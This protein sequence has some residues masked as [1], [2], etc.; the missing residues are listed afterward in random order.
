MELFD[1]LFKGFIPGDAFEAA[2]PTRPNSSLWIQQ[3]ILGI[4]D[5]GSARP[6]GANDAEWMIFEGSQTIDFAINEMDI[7]PAPS[8]TNAADG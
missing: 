7:D 1:P 3:A 2:F 8:I 5:F 4:D 6:T